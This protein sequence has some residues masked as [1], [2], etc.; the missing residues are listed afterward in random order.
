MSFVKSQEIK[1]QYMMASSDEDTDN[2]E[3]NTIQSINHSFTS[4]NIQIS[5]V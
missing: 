5:L 2:D 3:T 1:T 4:N